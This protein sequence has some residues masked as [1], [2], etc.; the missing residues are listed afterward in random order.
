MIKFRV[1]NDYSKHYTTLNEAALYGMVV[2]RENELKNVSNTPLI[3]E[4][5]TGLKDK[6]GKEIYEG[7]TVILTDS[8]NKELRCHVEY[9]IGGFWYVIEMNQLTIGMWE[10]HNVMNKSVEIIGNIHE[11]AQQ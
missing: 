2:P 7:D 3:L 8:K 6:N 4:Q 9:I 11:G 10:Y 5:Y 1:W